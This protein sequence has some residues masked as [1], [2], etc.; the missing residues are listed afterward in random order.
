MLDSLADDERIA[1]DGI[2]ATS[3]GAMN[4]VV[5]AYGWSVGGSTGARGAR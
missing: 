2:S 4:A 3:A 5:F 1:F